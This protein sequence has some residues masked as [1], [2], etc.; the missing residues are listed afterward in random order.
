MNDLEGL[1]LFLT[2][3]FLYVQCSTEH[4]RK[5]THF[6][7]FKCVWKHVN[8]NLFLKKGILENH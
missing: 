8:N 2:I 5:C 6:S 1:M 4:A 7:L 3:I